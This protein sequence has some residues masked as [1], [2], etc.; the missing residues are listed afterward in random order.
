[1]TD[2]LSK[3]QRSHNMAMIKS[4]NTMPEIRLRRFLSAK[5][6]KGFS[7]TSKLSGSPDIVYKKQ[8][9]TIFVDGCFWHKCK[10]HFV[11]PKTHKRF[12]ENKINGNV[13]RDIKVNRELR[14]QGYTVLRFFEH[15]INS[16]LTR[17][18]IAIRNKLIKKGY[19]RQDL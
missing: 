1:M 4:K 17:C 3:E 10:I 16:N 19:Y 15:S 2:N 8:K 7:L 18:Y 6:L 14:K 13:A 9:V 12:W 11:A 5:G